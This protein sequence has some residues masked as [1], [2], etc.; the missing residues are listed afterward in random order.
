MNTCTHLNFPQWEHMHHQLIPNGEVGIYNNVIHLLTL[1]LSRAK[2]I[3][4][5][6]MHVVQNK[7]CV[8]Q[9]NVVSKQLTLYDQ[10]TISC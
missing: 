5:V 4:T 9:E 8:L 10:E 1:T 2:P 3:F 6:H 7:C